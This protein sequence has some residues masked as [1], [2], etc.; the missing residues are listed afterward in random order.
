MDEIHKSQV[1]RKQQRPA[2]S[3]GMMAVSVV[4][5]NTGGPAS[6]RGIA[7]VQTIPVVVR[8]IAKVQSIPL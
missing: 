5:P 2:G 7:T 8:G 1:Q 4:Q 3:S 6:G